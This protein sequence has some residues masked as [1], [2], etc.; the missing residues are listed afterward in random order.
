MAI[1]GKWKRAIT[2]R[3]LLA[4][5]DRL[6][7]GLEVVSWATE[8]AEAPLGRAGLEPADQ[9]GRPTACRARSDLRDAGMR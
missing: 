7:T 1:D 4:V 3:F 8:E 9:R 6:P 2:G 5:R